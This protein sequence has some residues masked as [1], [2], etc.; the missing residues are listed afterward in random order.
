MNDISEEFG[1]SV[2]GSHSRHT[3]SE[4]FVVDDPVEHDN[5]KEIVEPA[6]THPE[7]KEILSHLAKTGDCSF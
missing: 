7:L 5:I 6:D 1:G 2:L 4:E 3:E